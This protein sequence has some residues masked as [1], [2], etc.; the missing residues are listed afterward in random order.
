M[1]ENVPSPCM[2]ICRM[3]S[4]SGLCEGCFRSLDEIR[5]WSQSDDA[6]K[7]RIWIAL[8]ER[9]RLAHPQAFARKNSA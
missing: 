5:F 4:H 2:S 7:K 8:A 1:A 6:A 9:L 3:D